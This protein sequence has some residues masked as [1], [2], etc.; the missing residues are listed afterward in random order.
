VIPKRIAQTKTANLYVKSKITINLEDVTPNVLK[1]LMNTATHRDPYYYN[2]R[3]RNYPTTGM[4]PQI[5]TYELNEEQIVLWRGCLGNVI[6]ILKSADL[7]YKIHDERLWLPQLEMQHGIKLRDYQEHPVEVMIKRQQTIGR[8]PCSS[9]KTECALYA[10]AHFK[11]PTLVLVWQERQQGVWLERV[12][13]WFNFEAGGI[14]GAFKTPVI[15]PITI[16]LLQS[17]RNKLDQYSNKFGAVICD[18]VQ[19]FSA[20]S[21]SE[22]INN[23]PA[24]IRLGASDDER[25][26]D[27]REFLLYD[28]FGPLS[29]NLQK[30]LG[31]CEV[32]TYIVETP[33]QYGPLEF[34][35][36][37]WTNLIQD[38]TES[39][40]RNKMIVDL[41]EREA[42]EGH[43]IIIWSDRVAHCQLLKYELEKRGVAVGLLIGGT[44]HKAEADSTQQGLNDGLISVGIGTAVAE[45]SI[46]VPVLDR[47]IM[48][49][50]SGDPKLLRFKQMRGRLARP[51]PN[52]ES[53]LYYLWDKNVPILYRR[54]YNIKR[55][56]PVQVIRQETKEKIE[57]RKN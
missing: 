6:R 51:Y 41:A 38:I 27:E 5:K 12:R 16:G 36:E 21:F 29:W 11:Q 14:G 34:I 18:E 33:F 57:C 8:G 17:V 40:A 39:K 54:I 20:K 43:K 15:A 31:Q 3:R 25:R 24:A 22:V 35:P 7:K 37:H 26:R 56:Y 55:R 47:G 30:D 45:Q 23:M 49:C 10:I 9:G 46:N 50:A 42:K 52:K 44:N 13:R 48:T 1:S 2:L 53:K 4:S 32:K 28:T 19:R